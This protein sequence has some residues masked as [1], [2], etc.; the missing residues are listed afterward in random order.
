MLGG[1]VNVELYSGYPIPLRLHQQLT[2]TN[3]DKL[4]AAPGGP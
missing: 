3:L 2:E 4:F 1:I